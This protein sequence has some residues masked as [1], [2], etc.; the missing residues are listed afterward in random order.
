[1]SFWPFSKREAIVPFLGPFTAPVIQLF[2]ATDY[3]T[4]IYTVPDNMYM[5]PLFISLHLALTAA[6]HAASGPQITFARGTCIMAITPP[7]A[8]PASFVGSL[9]YNPA[10]PTPATALYPRNWTLDMP[11]KLY[12]YPRDTITYYQSNY[13]ALDIVGP[14]CMHCKLWEVY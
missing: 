12:L 10:T 14:A 6:A 8:T 9:N 4:F 7:I 3:H 13:V 11:R 2:P 1:M 5:Q